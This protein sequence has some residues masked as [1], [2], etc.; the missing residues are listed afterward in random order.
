M[1]VFKQMSAIYCHLGG[2][3]WGKDN[4]VSIENEIAL[5]VLGQIGP[6]LRASFCARMTVSK[7]APCL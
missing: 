1:L 4:C 6:T 3:G 2:W 5:N 7:G